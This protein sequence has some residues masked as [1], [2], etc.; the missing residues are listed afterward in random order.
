MNGF[1]WIYLIMFAFLLAYD[2]VQSRETRKL[3]Y[4]C[5]CGFLILMFVLQDSSVS[6]DM[7]EYMRQWAIIPHLSFPQMLVHKFEIG[8]VLLCYVL[9]KLFVSDRIIL[10]A[11]SCIV[12]P[13]FGRF[14]A[15]ET[16]HPM[17][18]MML[19]VALGMYLHAIIFWRQL[20]AMAILTVSFRY[21]RQRRFLP[22]SFV[23]L[24]AMSF[25]KVAIVYFVL[26]FLYNVPV[27]K[28][29][30]LL[31]GLSAGLLGLFGREIIEFG[32][33]T[34]Y[35][36]Y[37]NVPR[38][39]MGGETLLVVLWIIVLFSYWL[40]KPHMHDGFVR[41]PF[42]MVLIA[43]TIQPV[44]FGYYNWF[45]VVLFFRIALI[46]LAVL[47]YTHLFRVKDGNRILKQAKG[48]SEN[49]YRFLLESFDTKWF[50]AAV[51]C[52]MFTVLFLWYLTELE[53]AVYRMV[54]IF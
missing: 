6:I 47:L 18:A 24:L 8:Y 14:Y 49:L 38:V 2:L 16:D 43:A 51:K 19:F 13:M 11:V 9:E 35:P 37:T 10:L 15:K 36:R 26:Y 34:I 53:G 44:C 21:I 33:A 39:V 23:V 54:P 41:L 3:I 48:I 50:P 42:L 29:L 1:Y 30:I 40:L 22:F 4:C 25:H 45:R 5:A 28:W 27:S 12:I 20:I 46:P 31:C 32:I 52:M 17:L 7:A